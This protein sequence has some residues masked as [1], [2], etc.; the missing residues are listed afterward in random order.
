MKEES[1]KMWRCA[2]DLMCYCSGEPEWEEQPW[3]ERREETMVLPDVGGRCKCDPKTCQKHLTF[4]EMLE[5]RLR[6]GAK[7]AE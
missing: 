6:K 3:D 5:A 1:K 7:D 4:S 2:N